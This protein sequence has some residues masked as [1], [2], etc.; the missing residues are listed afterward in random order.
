MVISGI[1]KIQSKIKSKMSD[2]QKGHHH[3]EGAKENMRKVWII[4]KQMAI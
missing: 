3:S 1:Y 2:V 4:R